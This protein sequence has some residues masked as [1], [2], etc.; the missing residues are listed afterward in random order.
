MRGGSGTR[1]IFFVSLCDASPR[2]FRYNVYFLFSNRF[3]FPFLLIL[4]PSD[5]ET[6]YLFGSKDVRTVRLSLL[7]FFAS[8]TE[9]TLPGGQGGVTYSVITHIELGAQSPLVLFYSYPWVTGQVPGMRTSGRLITPDEPNIVQS[10]S[11]RSCIVKVTKR[12]I[13]SRL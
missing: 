9:L 6:W 13:Y 11:C 12:M 7:Y 2:C 5:T 3:W 10:I 1:C 4:F 8:F